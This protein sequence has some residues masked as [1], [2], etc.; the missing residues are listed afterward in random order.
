MRFIMLKILDT[1][2]RIYAFIR[3]M[4]TRIYAFFLA[5]FFSWACKMDLL[6]FSLKLSELLYLFLSYKYNLVKKIK[7]HGFFFF[8]EITKN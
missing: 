8:M 6:L 5:F 1:K 3:E 7:F 4:Q 2:T